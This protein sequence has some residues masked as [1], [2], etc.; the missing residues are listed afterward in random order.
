[1]IKRAVIASLLSVGCDVLDLRSAP[2]PIAR[3]FIKASG[4]AGAVNTRKLPGNS[5]VTL[6]E[7][8]D[9]RGAYLS[10]NM[11][12]KVE[13]AFFREDFKRTDP[14]ELGVIDFASR[15]IE[16]YQSDFFRFLDG[17]GG[18]KRLRVAID[19]G[20]SALAGYY[21]AM[22]ARLGVETIGLNSYNDAKLA[23]RTPQEVQSHVD[24]LKR[25][26][27]TLGYDMGVLITDEGERLWLVDERGQELTGNAL[28][29]SLCLLVSRT[30]PGAT[31][32]LSVTAPT[33]LEE[34]LTRQ[35]ASVI[36]TK[37]EVRAL[38]GTSLD[39]G[40]T[41]AGDDRGGFI[42]PEMHPGFDAP[43]SFGLLVTMLQKSGL[44]LS[45]VAAEV[46]AFPV[47]YE[48]VRCPWEAKGAVMRKISE[49]SRDG[50]HVE[51]LDGIKIYD[52]D[53]WVLVLPDAVEPL[54]HVYAESP[55]ESES[56]KLVD[57]TIKK[58]E[59]LQETAV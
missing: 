39:A 15:A 25:I 27:G 23:P 28:L 43:F 42:F 51:L 30:H 12:R 44:T 45:E 9:S 40:V 58:I 52:E 59:R 10:R 56:Q 53:S 32:A 22:L 1:M 11:E 5:R 34:T 24:N 16:E 47:A 2:V 33:R 49:E 35:G 13:T 7:L 41:F 37:A 8:L 46:P 57:D 4:A 21:P 54:F 20:Y 29:A 38:I 55:E 18:G 36:R 48:Q 26:V 31:F 19:Y 3:H 6:I 50:S 14:D 17:H